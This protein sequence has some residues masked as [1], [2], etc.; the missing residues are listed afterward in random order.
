MCI[1]DGRDNIKTNVNLTPFYCLCN[2][3]HNT[4]KKTKKKKKKSGL[5][6]LEIFLASI[7]WV[8][9]PKRIF[10]FLGER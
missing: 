1:Y 4:L 7:V 2:T 8:R 6:L 10:L 5:I 9:K 3:L